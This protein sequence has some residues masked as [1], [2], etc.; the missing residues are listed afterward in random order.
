MAKEIQRQK[1]LASPV[2][3]LN[4][5][6]TACQVTPGEVAALSSVKACNSEHAVGTL[7]Y[8]AKEWM[9]QLWF[10]CS[11]PLGSISIFNF[12]S[13][14]FWEIK[15]SASD[16]WTHFCSTYGN[17][18]IFNLPNRPFILHL[19]L[20]NYVLL[21]WHNFT[22]DIY[23]VSYYR[24]SSQFFLTS[25]VSLCPCC[26]PVCLLSLTMWS[27]RVGNREQGNK[28]GLSLAGWHGDLVIKE[29]ES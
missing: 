18:T 26:L 10:I 12:F 29:Q 8:S 9:D 23:C 13:S 22:P 19:F 5:T 1:R 24:L 16:F 2:L 11:L 28:G 25:T 14:S 4:R 20:C 7:R 21:P 17:A 3:S 15:K 27:W 6:Q